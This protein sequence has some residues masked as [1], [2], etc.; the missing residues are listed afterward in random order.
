MGKY[1][2][3]LDFNFKDLVSSKEFWEENFKTV[4]F[5]AINEYL[6]RNNLSRTDFANKIGV[7]RGY[8]SQLMNGDSDHRLSKLIEL[9]ISIGKAP[10]LYLKDIEDV[11]QNVDLEKSVNIDFKKVEE[12]AIQ[13]DYLK[14]KLHESRIEKNKLTSRYKEINRNVSSGSGSHKSDQP[15]NYR[16]SSHRVSKVSTVAIYAA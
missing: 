6:E 15:I 14:D 10:Y 8:I 2:S 5:E 7:S 11:L 3:G 16:D 9:S 13:C 1:K 4:F 12:K